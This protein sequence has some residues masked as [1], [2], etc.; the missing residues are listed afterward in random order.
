MSD[1]A[2]PL[3]PDETP[4]PPPSDDD[5]EFLMPGPTPTSNEGCFSWGASWV[6]VSLV[7]LVIVAVMTIAC[8]A[9]SLLVGLL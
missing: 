1:Q 6:I 5:H 7:L 2:K 4:A 3:D 9:I 8:F